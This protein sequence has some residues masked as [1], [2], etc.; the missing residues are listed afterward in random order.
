MKE[1]KIKISADGSSVET[2]VSGI[3]GPSCQD[4][5]KSLINALGM[6]ESSDKTDEY[7][8]VDEAVIHNHGS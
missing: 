8:M 4:I 6:V 5:T 1:I 2:T 7:F 3:R